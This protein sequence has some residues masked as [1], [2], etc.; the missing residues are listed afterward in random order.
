MFPLNANHNN[1]LISQAVVF[2]LAVGFSCERKF[3]ALDAFAASG[4]E[5]SSRFLLFVT[6]GLVSLAYYNKMCFVSLG[7]M[8]VCVGVVR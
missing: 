6:F 2:G 7:V 1:I 3:H 8:D 5:V 4:L